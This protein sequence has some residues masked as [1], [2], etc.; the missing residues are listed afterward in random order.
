ME[1][2]NDVAIADGKRDAHA[3]QV[4]GLGQ[5]IEFDADIHRTGMDRKDSP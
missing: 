5:R 1:A 3:G 4:V 2:A